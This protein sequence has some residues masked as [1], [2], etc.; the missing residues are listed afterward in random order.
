MSA[1]VNILPHYTYED[2]CKWEGRWE[3][4]DGIP[5]A[6]S[7]APTIRHQRICA[8]VIAEFDKVLSA[9]PCNRDCKVY[10]FIDLKIAEDT[11]VQPDAAVI[12]GETPEAFLDFPPLIVVEVLSSSTRTKDLMSKYDRYQRFGV[13]YYMI[14]DPNQHTIDIY[15]LIDGVYRKQDT[16]SS[17]QFH[18]RL[19][20]VCGITLPLGKIWE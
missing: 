14:V 11:I 20:E 13:Q 17:G 10:N 9:V 6:M 19:N 4:I 15:E 5:Y 7:P 12:C 1:L 8:K 18:F 3:I 2:Y 16:G